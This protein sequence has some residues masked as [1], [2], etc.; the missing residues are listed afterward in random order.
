MKKRGFTLAEILVALGIV[1]VISAMAIPTFVTN[2]QQQANEAKLKSTVTD[3]ENAFASMITGEV[4]EDYTETKFYSNTSQAN[5][6]TY[7]KLNGSATSVSTYYG[8]SAPF[9]GANCT[10]S[11]TISPKN[12]FEAKNGSLL[13]FTSASKVFI[14]VNG[15]SKPNCIDRDIFELEIDSD[16]LITK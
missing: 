13:L 3:L 15:G 10:S 16:G 7:L 8:T 9:K 6:N 5:L 4:V 12:I 11:K 14:D 2:C 1:G